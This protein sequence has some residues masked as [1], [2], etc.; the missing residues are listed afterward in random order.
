MVLVIKDMLSARQLTRLVEVLSFPDLSSSVSQGKA[1]G[2][3]LAAVHG[4]PIFHLAVQPKFL[5]PLRFLRCEPGEKQDVLVTEAS[6]DQLVRPDVVISV[7]LNAPDQYDGGE[8]IIDTGYGA[9]AYKESAGSAVVYAVSASSRMA[10][11]SR[12]RRLTVEFS[13]Q[14]LVRDADAR[15]ILYDVSSAERH[16]EV[17]GKGRMADLARLRRTREALQQ[18]WWEP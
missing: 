9:E 11:V 18:M 10:P 16:V 4:H 2:F 6:A 8:L 7:F 17:F 1:S 15:Q 14:S 3:V 12:G 5:S 13:A